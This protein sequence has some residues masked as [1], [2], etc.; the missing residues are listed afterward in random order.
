MCQ[1]LGECPPGT[2]AI[3]PRGAE[4]H[5]GP[6]PTCVLYFGGRKLKL[7]FLNLR[8][9]WV[10]IVGQGL[11]PPV[12]FGR[13]E[14]ARGHLPAAL[15]APFWQ[16]GS[17]RRRVS[18]PAVG[19]SVH[20]QPWPQQGRPCLSPG[21]QPCQRIPELSSDSDNLQIPTFLSC[22]GQGD[23]SSRDSALRPPLPHPATPTIP[24]NT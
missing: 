13:W 10:Q 8:E 1:D 20:P 19:S 17:C 21:S 3:S 9:C 22:P 4:W 11:D 14:G 23:R 5:P 16:A 24:V 12:G 15:A 7:H 6:V 2:N 18:F